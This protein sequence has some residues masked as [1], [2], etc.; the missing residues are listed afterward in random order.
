MKSL[1]ITLNANLVWR[2]KLAVLAAWNNQPTEL[3]DIT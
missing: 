3:K 1:E 2:T